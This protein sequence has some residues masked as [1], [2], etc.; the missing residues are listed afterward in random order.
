MGHRG[1]LPLNWLRAFEAAARTGRITIAAEELAVTHGA[2][3]RQVSQLAAYVNVPL[4]EGP[5]N[6]PTLTAAGADLLKALTPAFDQIDAALQAARSGDEGLLDVAC[7][8]TF[9]VRWLIPRLHRF[10]D[11]NPRVEVR[12]S[13]DDRHGDTP[14]GRHDLIILALGPDVRMATS[15]TMLFGERLGVVIAPSLIPSGEPARV[16]HL[17]GLPRL[18]TRTRPDAWSA[19]CEAAGSRWAGPHDR[20]AAE[21]EHY[22]FTIEAAATGLGACI[23]PLHLVADSLRSGRLVA[24][25]GFIDSGYRYVARVVRPSCR[26]VVRFAEWLRN[27]AG[28]D[29]AAGLR[30]N[31]GVDP[32]PVT[33]RGG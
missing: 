13:T 23:A 5:R 25:L 33:A 4:F 6:R 10:R 22:A 18:A 29:A 7:Y 1:A 15:D 2:V 17:A 3:S 31:E 20:P 19:W 28:D 11:Q 32:A 26:K 21:F 27:E 14:R 8:S 12:V 24:P 16:E 9:A 30:P